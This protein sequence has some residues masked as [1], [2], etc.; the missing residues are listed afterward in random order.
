MNHIDEPPPEDALG[1]ADEP[2]D[3]PDSCCPVCMHDCYGE[4]PTRYCLECDWTERPVLEQP[5]KAPQI[6][7]PRDDIE[8]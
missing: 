5:T 3:I 7:E 4:R 2:C 8:F 1:D 6:V